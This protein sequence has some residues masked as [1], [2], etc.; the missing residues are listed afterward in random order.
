[1]L[2]SVVI[3]QFGDAIQFIFERRESV[4]GG[5]EIGG[6]GEIGRL[7]LTHLEVSLAGLGAATAVALPLGLV[8]G[9]KGRGEF[10]AIAVSNVGRAVPALALLAF[11][12]AYIGTGF[13]NV[14]LVMF[15]LALPPILTN[16]YVGIRQ[17]DRDVVDS[18]RGMGMSDAQIIRKVELPLAL[19]TIFG[20]IRLGTVFVVATA[21]IAP[22]A[23][24]RTLGEPIINEQIYGG[25]GQLGAA[26]VVALITLGADAGIGL[27]QRAVTP[28]GL[29][30]TRE[31]GRPRRRGRISTALPTRREKT[32]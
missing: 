5:V 21:T 29:K 27:V 2:S 10:V 19:P 24:V 17:V 20:G 6:L 30:L 14:A 15:L 25:A 8:L 16:T 26:M 22:Y 23:D 28:K 32:I 12:L 9:H 13:L 4:S 3:A 11:F 1:M 31:E 7:G 18:A